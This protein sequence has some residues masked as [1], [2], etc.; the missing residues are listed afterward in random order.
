[1][2][3]NKGT[4]LLVVALLI[5]LAGK[6]QLMTSFAFSAMGGGSNGIMGLSSPIMLDG[7]APCLTVTNGVKLMSIAENGT[8]AFAA[9]CKETAPVAPSP[10]AISLSL[11]VYPNPTKG[12]SILKCQGSFDA[13]LSCKIQ[14]VGMDGRVLLSRVA[15]VT[16]VQAGL[17]IDMSAQAPGT[18]SVIVELMNQRYSLRLIKL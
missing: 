9:S 13:G 17:M 4:Y 5:S 12:M 1:M 18:Y 8:G 10:A 6:S 2:R 3:F 16:A 15:A 14:V 7:K 11:T